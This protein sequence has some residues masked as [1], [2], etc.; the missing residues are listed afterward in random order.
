MEAATW[1]LFTLAVVGVIYPYAGYPAV[2]WL[3]ARSRP[4]FRTPGPAPS[5]R[6]TL[7]VPVHNESVRLEAKIANTLALEYPPQLLEVLFISD[8][9]TDG[10]AELIRS[11][12]W[13]SAQLI[14]LERRKGKAA[15]LNAG[16]AAAT[17]DI[18]VFTDAAIALQPN[19]LK[20]IV[21]PFVDP[22]VGC[23]SGE[24]RI[25]DGG[26]E[27][28]YGRYELFLRR[29][30]S[31][32]YSIVGASGSFYA[33]RR[34][35][36]T[37]FTEGMAPDFLSVLRTVGKGYRAVSQPSAVGMMASVKEVRQEFDRKVRTLLRGMTA[38]FAHR[39]LLN[40]FKHGLFAFALWSHKILRWTVPFFLVALFLVSA[41]RMDHPFFVAMVVAQLGF[42]GTAV[43]ALTRKAGVHATAAGRIALYFSTVNAAI[44]MAW[45]RYVRG[46]RQEIW[47]PSTR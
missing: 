40:P 37:P 24:D 32:A 47:T 26:G 2:L 30:E 15:A 12:L 39:E 5:P 3:I 11:R 38:L 20:A 4:R 8:G 9:S 10:S 23:V 31:D 21:R 16:I 45:L 1:L 6:V 25:A 42:Y 33:Q 43:L 29:L 36:C 7:I 35:L 13:Q 46:V 19:A 44:L 18:V 41:V 27:G 17:G 22:V 14:E 34:S 28:L